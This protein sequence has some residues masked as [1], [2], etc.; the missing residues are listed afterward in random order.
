EIDLAGTRAADGGEGLVDA[1]DA[2][3]REGASERRERLVERRGGPP[4]GGHGGRWRLPGR[5][6]PG[7][8]GRRGPPPAGRRPRRRRGGRCGRRRPAGATGGEDGEQREGTTPRRGDHGTPSLP[9][10]PALGR[11]SFPC[12][13]PHDS[14]AVEAGG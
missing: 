7:P 11:A 13:R 5:G 10:P 4:R 12:P 8:R 2:D 3:P 1:L 9:A 14:F 6:P